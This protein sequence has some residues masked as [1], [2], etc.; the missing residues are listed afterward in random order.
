MNQVGN[1]STYVTNTKG[2]G[3]NKKF[4]K[5]DKNKFKKN[6]KKFPELKMGGGNNDYRN[7]NY[8]MSSDDEVFNVSK[9]S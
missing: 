7:S 3:Q 8:T 5:L 1:S 2:T 6:S 4:H 9:V